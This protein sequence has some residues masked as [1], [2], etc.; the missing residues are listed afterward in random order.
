MEA[1]FKPGDVVMTPHG[2][3]TVLCSEL[4]N[5]AWPGQTPRMITTG[6]YVVVLE[7]GHTW[8]IKTSNPAYWPKELKHI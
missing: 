6:R 4:A 2:K 3:G 1:I 8:A 5:D 7:E